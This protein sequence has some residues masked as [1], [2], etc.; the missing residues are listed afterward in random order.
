VEPAC[1]APD[2]YQL[3]DTGLSTDVIETIFSARAYSTR[4][5]YANKW[6]VFE[7]WCRAYNAD[8]VDCQIALVLNFLQEKLSAGI[9]PTTLRIYVATLLTCHALVDGVPLGRHPLLARFIRVAKRL[10]PSVRTKISSWDLAIVLEG[11]VETPLN[12]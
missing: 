6:G 7:R 8:P 11:L 1:L 2:W 3:R 5:S 4:K 10:R 12:L 9:C